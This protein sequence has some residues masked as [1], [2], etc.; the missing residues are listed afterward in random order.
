MSFIGIIIIM[1]RGQMCEREVIRL[2]DDISVIGL[3]RFI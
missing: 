1:I 3:P 2:I